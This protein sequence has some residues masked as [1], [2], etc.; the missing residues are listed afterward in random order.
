VSGPAA[1]VRERPILFSGPM[2]RAILAGRKTQTRRVVKPQPRRDG[3]GPLMWRTSPYSAVGSFEGRV[4]DEVLA[5]CPYGASGDRLW[6]RE[7]WALLGDDDGSPITLDGLQCSAGEAWRLYRAD[8]QPTKYG[9]DL[10]PGGAHFD[11]RWRPSIHMPRWASRLSLEVLSVRVE[12]LQ[13]ISEE[14]AKAEGVQP[15]AIEVAHLGE[16]CGG[17]ALTAR[18][19]FG[20]LWD[21]ING[22]RAP[23]A[24]NPW[25]WR[26]E[27]RRVEA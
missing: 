17:G 2:V 26:V 10:L 24:D 22:D 23:W 25:V 13:E 7:T 16:V 3:D 15:I 9:L 20:A 6:V 12:R 5:Q 18:E 27:F 19:Q 11:G 14:D 21:T 1:T 8:T 4:P